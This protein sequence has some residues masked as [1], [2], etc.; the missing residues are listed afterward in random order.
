MIYV[1]SPAMIVSHLLPDTFWNRNDSDLLLNKEVNKCK[2]LG[3]ESYIKQ[4][5]AEI[6]EAKN[7]GI[8]HFFRG[9]VYTNIQTL[10][11]YFT[12]IESTIAPITQLKV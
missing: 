10:M 1:T 12:I 7:K 2:E 3:V 11:E 6:T 4:H 5:N 8:K 9:Y